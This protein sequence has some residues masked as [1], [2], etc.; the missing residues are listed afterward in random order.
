VTLTWTNPTGKV[1]G[2]NVYRDNMKIAW[3]GWPNPVVTSYT[4]SN[5]AAGSHTYQVAAY[6]GY[7]QGPVVSVTVTVA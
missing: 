4:D 1:D 6:N 7:G 5:V 2:D 3:P